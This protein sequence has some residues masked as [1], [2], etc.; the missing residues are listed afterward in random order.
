MQKQ[1]RKLGSTITV[2]S[3]ARL[4]SA[5]GKERNEVAG[6]GKRAAHCRQGL[7]AACAVR[8]SAGGPSCGAAR[9]CLVS[10]PPGRHTVMYWWRTPC[11]KV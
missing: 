7:E 2:D 8:N 3:P 11:L 5:D 9:C 4:L 10:R 1:S 6:Q